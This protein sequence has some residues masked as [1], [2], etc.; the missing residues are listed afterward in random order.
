MKRETGYYWVKYYGDW[1]ICFYHSNMELWYFA[2]S[3][4]TCTDSNFAEID[5]CKLEPPKQKE[6][7]E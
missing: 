7:E 5:E 6:I 3:K 4:F 2:G 1:R